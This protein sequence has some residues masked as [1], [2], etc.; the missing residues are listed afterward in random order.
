MAERKMNRLT[1]KDNRTKLGWYANRIEERVYF[2]L[3]Q[4]ENLEEE[5]GFDLIPLLTALTNGY[6]F[7]KDDNFIY[8]VQINSITNC[9]LKVNTW[10]YANY[11]KNGKRYGDEFSI[12]FKD[13]GK[14]W[15]LSREDLENETIL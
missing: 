5:L 6:V 14:T 8:K 4:L 11:N 12:D 15:A 2:K 10:Y 1:K 13:Y 9:C 7:W 3:F